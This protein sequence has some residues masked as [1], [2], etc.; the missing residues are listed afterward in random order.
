MDT[1]FSERH[2]IYIYIVCINCSVQ[3]TWLKCLRNAALQKPISPRTLR[4]F[5]AYFQNPVC[6]TLICFAYQHL[7]LLSAGIC[8]K[9]ERALPGDF[10]SSKYFCSPDPP[11]LPVSSLRL[12]LLACRGLNL[13]L[14]NTLQPGAENWTRH[15]IISAFHIILLGILNY[16]ACSRSNI[17]HAL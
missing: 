2:D 10:Q 17:L 9:D 8:Q 12:L 16:G 7:P 14:K 11:S 5:S 3:R 1:V 6:I 4:C 15:F 13:E